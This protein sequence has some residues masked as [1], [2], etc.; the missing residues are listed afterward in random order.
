MTQP[1]T[2]LPL[3]I[4]ILA[5][6][7]VQAETR[8]LANVNGRKYVSVVQSSHVQATPNWNPEQGTNPS[9][10]VSEAFSM[11]QNVLIS[12]FDNN[13]KLASLWTVSEFQIMRLESWR[14]KDKWCYVINYSHKETR[15]VFPI[16]VLFDGTALQPQAY[17]ESP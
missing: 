6:D 2:L 11:A 5:L 16:V 14:R 17:D 10:A 13:M 3:I 8:F 12:F 4:C 1:N 9:L 7:T 15:D